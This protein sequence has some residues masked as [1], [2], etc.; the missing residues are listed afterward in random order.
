MGDTNKRLKYIRRPCDSTGVS[1]TR[2]QH[3]DYEHLM[4]KV[5]LDGNSVSKNRF[6]LSVLLWSGGFMRKPIFLVEL[7]VDICEENADTET[8]K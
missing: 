5:I 7:K 6:S 3:N 1:L 4:Q 8:K 2:L